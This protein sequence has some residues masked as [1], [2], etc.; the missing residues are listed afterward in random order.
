MAL[1][2]ELGES[3]RS[4]WDDWS[5]SCADKFSDRDQHKTW[6]SFRRD[7]VRIGTLFHLAQEY[8]WRSDYSSFNFN[9]A[10]ADARTESSDN[11]EID[12]SCGV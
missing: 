11:P 4:L 3:G 9:G 5:A 8:G 2:A 1:K 7:G 12:L 6:Q 10:R